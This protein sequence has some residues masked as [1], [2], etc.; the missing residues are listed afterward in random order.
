VGYSPQARV[1][2]CIELKISKPWGPDPR[3]RRTV[4]GGPR[5]VQRARHSIATHS[6]RSSSGRP[7]VNA[8]P[9]LS[10]NRRPKP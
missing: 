6:S 3:L 7:I 2:S 9:I 5:K 4:D 10:R 1:A 8:G